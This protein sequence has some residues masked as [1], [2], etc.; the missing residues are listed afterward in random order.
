[1]DTC[2]GLP[3]FGPG[4]QNWSRGQ[5]VIVAAAPGIVVGGCFPILLG[6]GLRANGGVSAATAEPRPCDHPAAF[7]RSVGSCSLMAASVSP[8]AR[9]CPE[10]A[11][12]RVTGSK[13]SVFA[14]RE[15]CMRAAGATIRGRSTLDEMLRRIVAPNA[16]RSPRPVPSAVSVGSYPISVEHYQP[17]LDA[18]WIWAE[19]QRQ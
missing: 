8:A 14:A 15:K 13:F 6:V 19:T 16:V 5:W 18:D 10:A 11:A 3:V 1:M 7:L 2:D 9:C 12:S 17:S 4:L